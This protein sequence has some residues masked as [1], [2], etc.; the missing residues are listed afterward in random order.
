MNTTPEQR[1]ELRERA[2]KN[3]GYG[4]LFGAD[5]ILALL[6]DIEALERERDA[7]VEA[8]NWAC[9]SGTED[10]FEKPQAAHGP[11]WWRT[12]LVRMA[13]LMFDREKACYVTSAEKPPI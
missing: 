8:I 11:F 1:R 9:G 7:M 13:G 10:S 3:K 4:C 6:N 2:A 12:V 5:A